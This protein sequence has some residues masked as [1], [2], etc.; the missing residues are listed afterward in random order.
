M[1]ENKPG[2][3]IHLKIELKEMGEKSYDSDFDSKE[4]LYGESKN[5]LYSLSLGC[6]I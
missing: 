5:I 4:Y 2:D 1:H 3:Y 6:V